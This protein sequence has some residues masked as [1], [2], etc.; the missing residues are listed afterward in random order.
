MGVP[1]AIFT[2]VGVTLTGGLTFCFYMSQR[3]KKYFEDEA[4]SR[5]II[6]TVLPM[7]STPTSDTLPVYSAA[8]ATVPAVAVVSPTA[9]SPPSSSI[10]PPPPSSSSS[11]VSTSLSVTPA[12]P[13]GPRVDSYLP[14]PP[15]YQPIAIPR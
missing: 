10:L 7:S 15:S 12:G 14:P 11:V 13:G 1:V 5:R 6:M 8:V 4:A 9:L 3:Q 2:I